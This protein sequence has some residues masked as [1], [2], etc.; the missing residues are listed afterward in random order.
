MKVI[1]RTKK[2]VA[3]NIATTGLIA[4]YSNVFM[5]HPK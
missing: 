4:R 1:P 3:K 2:R 5:D